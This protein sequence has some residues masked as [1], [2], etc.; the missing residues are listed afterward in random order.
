[1]GGS[2]YGGHF[3]LHSPHGSVN[4]DTAQV[5]SLDVRSGGVNGIVVGGMSGAITASATFVGEESGEEE[6]VVGESG[7]T[8]TRRG[9]DVRVGFD[10]LFSPIQHEA[11]E[12]R[13]EQ[14]ERSML[15][16]DGDIHVALSDE[17]PFAINIDMKSQD[18][19]IVLPLDYNATG[20][21]E[22]GRQASTSDIKTALF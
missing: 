16:A 3:H 18:Q 17:T 20:A 10:Q 2:M 22:L 8:M 7:G 9:G 5:R 19:Q 1:M 13:S 12:E 4:V 21:P 6:I 15:K 11:S 14:P